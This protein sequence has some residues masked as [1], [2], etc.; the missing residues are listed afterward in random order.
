MGKLLF[1]QE[2]RTR[3][4][5]TFPALKNRDITAYRS[6]RISNRRGTMLFALVCLIQQRKTTETI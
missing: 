1:S 5:Q 4:A 6:G 2:E 3:T